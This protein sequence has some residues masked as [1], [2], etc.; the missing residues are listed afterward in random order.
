MWRCEVGSGGRRG[1]ETQEGEGAGDCAS[2]PEGAEA[3]EWPRSPGRRQS[4]SGLEFWPLT[5]EGT[6][7]RTLEE[8]L[9]RRK[10]PGG[11]RLP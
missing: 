8:A 9:G 2:V 5:N 10:A 7:P 3:R 1:S 6:Q 11:W 4:G